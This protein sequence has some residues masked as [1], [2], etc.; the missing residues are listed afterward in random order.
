MN[1]LNILYTTDNN[2]AP[3]TA[4]SM[5]SLLNAN[6]NFERINIYIID[7]NIEKDSKDNFYS[8]INGFNNAE[9]YF[10]P[11]SEL[12]KNVPANDKTGY[13]KVGYARLFLSGICDKERILYIDCDTIIN[14]SLK[15]LW[16]Y[17]L[18]GNVLGGVQ[19]N[20]A[21]YALTEI[22]LTPKSRY[23]NGGV[24]LIDLKKW[25]EF[26]TEEKILKMIREYNGFVIHHDQGIINGVL[27]DHIKI[28]PPKFNTMPQFFDTKAKQIKRLYDIEN[29]YSQKELDEAV[30][31]PVI[32]H[33][34]TKFYNRPW[35]KSCTHPLKNLYI[36]N[37]EKTPFEV[38]L[39]D[40]ELPTKIKLRRFVFNFFP[41]FIY[42]SLER[43]LNVK[44]KKKAGTK[45]F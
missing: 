45:R 33:Y 10:F 12:K 39:Y 25:K 17:D 34:I 16:E 23:I 37:I 28:L 21:L 20:P 32:I 5:Y 24:L 43:L 30:K 31:N 7:D 19:D 42:Y 8:I 2:Y 1:E 3:H 6:K 38:K 11:F 35:F 36:K 14:Q 18:E 9:I 15:E 22:G 29:Y 27:K 44:R 26:K 41:F 13:A 40:G 4:A